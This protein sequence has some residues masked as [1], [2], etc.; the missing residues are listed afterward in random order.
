MGWKVILTSLSPCTVMCFLREARS[1]K[2]LAHESRWH[3]NVLTVEPLPI[4]RPAWG[5]IRLPRRV[6]T[7]L[8]AISLALL[9][10]RDPSTS[11]SVFFPDL[12]CTW[13]TFGVTG[14]LPSAG[15]TLSDDVLTRPKKFEAFWHWTM[16]LS[17]KSKALPIIF[18]LSIR[19]IS[20]IK[21]E[22][23]GFVEKITY[24]ACFRV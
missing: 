15:V 23:G 12:R 8:E 6:E 22:V 16:S 1:L 3:L 14:C 10:R 11:Y 4:R 18:A 19:R 5:L 13:V 21:N 24:L 2:I 9:F 7:S 20:E 17:L